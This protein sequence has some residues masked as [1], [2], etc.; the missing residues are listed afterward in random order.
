MGNPAG[1]VKTPIKRTISTGDATKTQILQVSSSLSCAVCLG[2]GLAFRWL[3]WP[4]L[5]ISYFSRLRFPKVW[6]TALND[7]CFTAQ[8]DPHRQLLIA[9]C[10][11]WLKHIW[12]GINSSC[13]TRKEW[14]SVIPSQWR[15]RSTAGFSNQSF[16]LTLSH[17][18]SCPKMTFIATCAANAF[19]AIDSNGGDEVCFP[20]G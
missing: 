4:L 14:W 16:C 8:V 10:I 17:V 9:V 11:R 13:V 1:A 7:N 15:L 2:S 6:E 18:G 3:D 20:I 19:S 5:F 12:S